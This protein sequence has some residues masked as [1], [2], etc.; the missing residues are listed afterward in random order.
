MG[1]SRSPF[2]KLYNFFF[3]RAGL[4]MGN[5]NFGGSQ[6]GGLAR[7]FFAG[8]LP[9]ATIDY[10]REAGR[11][12]KNA[13]VAAAL[14]WISRSLPYA[15]LAVFVE[16]ADGQEKLVPKHP[17]AKLLK[18]PNPYYD[19]KTLLQATFL[20][21]VAGKG[22]AYWWV[23]RA[24]GG[25]PLEFWYLPHFDVW[26]IW[27]SESTTDNWI[28]GYAYRQNGQIQILSNDEVI[29]FR[30]GLDPERP[31]MGWDALRS[32]SREIVVDNGASSYAAQLLDNMCIPGLLIHPKGDG[33]FEEGDRQEIRDYLEQETGGANRFR[34]I[35]L[36]GDVVLEK[37]SLS[38]QEMTLDTM[39]DRPEARILSI[40]GISPMVLDLTVGLEHSTYSNKETAEKAAWYNCIMPRI[41]LICAELD[42]QVLSM[43]PGAEEMYLGGDY[44]K[45]MALQDNLDKKYA[46]LSTAVGGPFLTPDEARAQIGHAATE[47]GDKMYPP[48]AGGMQPEPNDPK[49]PAADAQTETVKRWRQ[50]SSSHGR[51]G[52]SNPRSKEIPLGL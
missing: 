50:R 44:R 33:I 3:K 19:G 29:H 34:P 4:P 9:G 23:R 39:Q 49:A 25:Q 45:V 16:S 2:A 31:R 35:A 40:I 5:S 12:W 26:P 15:P 46:R 10:E 1:E 52:K 37:M 11:A 13:I 47:G 36:S 8:L 38:P 7:N 24:N 18:R 14:A 21:L 51:N 41:A 32:V 22:N 20:S 43:F 6:F 42:T 17:L 27:D 28:S 30:D 48:K